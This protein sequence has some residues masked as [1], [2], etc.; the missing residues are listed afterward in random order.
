MSERDFRVGIEQV[1][2]GVTRMMV[3]GVVDARAA[4]EL[5]SVIDS[6]L[7]EGE[8]TLLLDL[9]GAE[10]FDST[11][12]GVALYLAK[13]L[14]KL[15]G[16][17]AVLCPDPLTRELFELAG[18]NFIFPVVDSRESALQRLGV[19]TPRGQRTGRAEASGNRG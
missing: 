11:A 5:R 9:S 3:G 2:S 18:L 13:R 12:L 19:G 7:D 15:G 10:F 16:T 4:P 6:L 1:D 8:R 17:L 14:R